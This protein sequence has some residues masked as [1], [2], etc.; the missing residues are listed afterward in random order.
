MADAVMGRI[1][2]PTIVS[3]KQNAQNLQRV[4]ENWM[5]GPDKASPKPDDV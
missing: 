5:L 4:V 2:T 3:A 1:T